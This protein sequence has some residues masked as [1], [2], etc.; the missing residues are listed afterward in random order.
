MLIEVM[1]SVVNKVDVVSSLAD[2]GASPD[3]D[4]VVLVSVSEVTEPIT[5]S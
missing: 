2:I 1:T 3:N 5:E 4:C